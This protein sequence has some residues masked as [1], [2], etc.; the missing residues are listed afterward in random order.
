MSYVPLY[1]QF[2][3]WVSICFIKNPLSFQSSVPQIH[4]GNLELDNFSVALLNNHWKKKWGIIGD[5]FKSGE[6]GTLRNC[7]QLITASLF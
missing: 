2:M 3:F 4:S 6:T 7:Q 1:G 5:F